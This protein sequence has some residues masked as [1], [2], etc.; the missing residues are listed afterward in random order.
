MGVATVTGCSFSGNSGAAAVDNTG[1][2]LTMSGTTFTTNSGGDLSGVC[3][4]GGSANTPS[5]VCP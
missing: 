3:T 5:S 2:T 1:G 4:N